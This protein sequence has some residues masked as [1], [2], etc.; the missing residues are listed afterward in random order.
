MVF[1]WLTVTLLLAGTFFMTVASIGIVRMPDVYLRMSCT[2]KAATLGSGCILAAYALQAHDVGTAVR[3]LATSLF[4][5]L[6]A[7]VAAHMI[8]RAAYRL[9]VPLW[10]GSC[11][12]ELK[13]A[14]SGSGDVLRSPAFAET[15]A[16]R[17][18]AP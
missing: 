17:D 1:E 6:T 5:I 16:S 18:A 12:D 7:P 13:G 8:G 14:Y 2:S 10:V 4:L 3:A 9:G 15:S 11:C